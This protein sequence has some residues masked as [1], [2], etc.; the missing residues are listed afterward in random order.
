MKNKDNFKLTIIDYGSSNLYS[1]INACKTFGIEPEVS[2]DHNTIKNADAVILPGVGAF[3]EAM[4]NL[5]RLGLIEPI[6]EFAQSGKPFM[7]ICLGLHLLFERSAE[8][9]NTEGLGLIKGSIKKFPSNMEQNFK[10]PQI[11]W[12]LINKADNNNWEKSPFSTIKEGAFMYFVHS[13]YA[14]A[15]D[16]EVILSK[17]KFNDVTY[18]SS[19]L[20]NN[21][22]ATQ[23]H[24]EKS[25]DLGLEIY[26]NWF[27]NIIQ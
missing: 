17:T 22:F 13:F 11:G 26:K 1:V 8:F 20:K 7:G 15:E 3:N 19:I 18:C 14:D 24:P 6:K 5:Q 10:V 2:S 27:S 12:N 9:G 25:G 21:I 16:P 23:F 4:S